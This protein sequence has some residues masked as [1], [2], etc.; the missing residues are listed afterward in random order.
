MA[1]L[2]IEIKFGNAGMLTYAQ[3]REVIQDKVRTGALRP[4]VGDG[5]RFLD[6]N[7]NAVGSWEVVE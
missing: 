4:H 3:A 7:G 5:G 1:K 2:V 6:V